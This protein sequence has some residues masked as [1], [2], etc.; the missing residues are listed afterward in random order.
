LQGQEKNDQRDDGHGR[1][2]DDQ[3][4]EA[5]VAGTLGQERPQAERDR[6]LALVGEH[7]EGQQENPVLPGCYPDPSICRV[8]EDFYLVTSSFAYYPGIP[9]FHSRDLVRWRQLTHVLNR[10]G[11]LPL[12][13]LDV[14]DG[15][16]GPRPSATTTARST[17]SPRWP[18]IGAGP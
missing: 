8:G 9:L 18:G 4:V 5:A 2:R 16:W 13:G 17:W 14:S 7:D 15:V 12:E 6:I 1:T 3:R 11:L 10:P